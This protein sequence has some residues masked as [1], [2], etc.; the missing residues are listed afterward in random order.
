MRPSRAAK[1]RNKFRRSGLMPNAASAISSRGSGAR[2][3]ATMMFAARFTKGRSFIKIWAIWLAGLR[4][5]LTGLSGR[6]TQRGRT[7]RHRRISSS[8]WKGLAC[9]HRTRPLDSI[10]RWDRW[11]SA[12]AVDRHPISH[13]R[14]HPGHNQ[15]P[16][17][18]RRVMLDTR[19]HQRRPLTV[20]PSTL[21][22][23]RH[24][25]HRLMHRCLL[26]VRLRRHHH[27]TMRLRPRRRFRVSHRCLRHLSP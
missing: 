4:S 21:A 20:D 17:G 24:L 10:D 7:W 5:R 25:R 13:L 18:N 9:R 16:T 22:R 6:G 1:K 14:C 23:R 15:A 2:H 26:P 11:T 27:H 12:A 3:R 8:G 19:S